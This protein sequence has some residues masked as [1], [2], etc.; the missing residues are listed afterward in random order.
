MF[1][2]IKK[3][4]LKNLRVLIKICSNSLGIWIISKKSSESSYRS[5]S[6]T[7]INNYSTLEDLEEFEELIRKRREELN[8]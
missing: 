5:T 2:T 8:K 3:E 1:L 6:R 4:L 7:F